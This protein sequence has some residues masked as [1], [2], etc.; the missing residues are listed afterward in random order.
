MTRKLQIFI[1]WMGVVAVITGAYRERLGLPPSFEELCNIR[2]R[3]GRLNSR[4]STQ[5]L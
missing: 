4:S 2:S 1:A 5:A 3:A